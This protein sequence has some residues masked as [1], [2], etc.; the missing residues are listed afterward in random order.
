MLGHGTDPAKVLRELVEAGFE[1]RKIRRGFLFWR[2][3]ASPT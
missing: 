3:L 2:V 1:P